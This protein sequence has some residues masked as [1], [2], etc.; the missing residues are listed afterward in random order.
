MV[1]K[2]HMKNIMLEHE[3][4]DD[5]D[6]VETPLPK[7]PFRFFH[8]PYELRLRVYELVLVVPK[9]IDL[10]PTNFRTITPLLRL[11]YVS[12]RM[13]DE[14]SRVF[15]GHNTFRIFPI[16]GRFIHAKAPLPA[17]VSSRNRA[18]ITKMEMRLGPSW[19]KP[20]RG[21]VM[22][23]RI[24]LADMAKLRLLKVFVECDPASHPVFEGFRV[25]ENFYTE[26]SLD[27]MKSLFAQAPSVAEVEFDAYPS[28][29]KSSPLLQALLDE[30]KVNNKRVTWGPERGWDKIVE[31]NLAN[32]MQGLSL[33]P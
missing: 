10:D 13:R 27:L 22:D 16:H 29:S 15:Y 6:E 12:H 26:F 28:V 2:K 25:G 11:F 20:P 23:T 19:T 21:W 33:G 14:A 4:V 8:L 32:F 30:V 18:L 17:R 7:Q 9:T 24:G 5:V 3:E 1:S 31:V